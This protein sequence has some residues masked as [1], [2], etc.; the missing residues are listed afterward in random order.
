MSEFLKMTFLTLSSIQNYQ[1]MNI[2]NSPSALAFITK[3][4]NTKLNVWR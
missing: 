3:G 1:V 4:T 2:L